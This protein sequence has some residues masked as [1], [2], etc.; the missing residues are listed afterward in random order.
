MYEGVER[1]EVS[2]FLLVH[3][4]HERAEVRMAG[5]DGCGLGCVDFGGGEFA[6]LV[7]AELY[8]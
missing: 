5:Y 1:A 3:V 7:D 8:N 4:G 6:G 2:G